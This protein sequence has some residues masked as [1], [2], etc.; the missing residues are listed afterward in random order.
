MFLGGG[1]RRDEEPGQGREGMARVER[2]RYMGEELRYLEVCLLA[3]KHGVLV[4]HK[5]L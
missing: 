2:R 3:E 1:R 5:S 4:A